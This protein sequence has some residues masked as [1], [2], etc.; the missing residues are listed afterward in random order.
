PIDLRLKQ[1]RGRTN[2]KRCAIGIHGD[3]H[4]FAVRRH[5]E[6][7]LTV[8]APAGR[9]TALCRYLPLSARRRESLHVD[10]RGSGFIGYVS[11]PFFVRRE[12]GDRLI[13]WRLKEKL[14]FLVSKQRQDP[15]IRA[16]L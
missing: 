16:G 2:L 1:C 14:W 7:F 15:K 10:L 4:D 13:K 12:P 6:Q 8:T 5:V 11:D 3:G 9:V